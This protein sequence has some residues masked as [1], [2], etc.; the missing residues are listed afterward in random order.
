MPPNAVFLHAATIGTL[1]AFKLRRR[2]RCNLAPKISRLHGLSSCQ[3]MLTNIN[4]MKQKSFRSCG[5]LRRSADRVSTPYIC[6]TC[7]GATGAALWTFTGLLHAW[8]LRLRR[9][10]STGAQASQTLPH[11]RAAVPR[12]PGVHTV[13]RRQTGHVA[14]GGRNISAL[15]QAYSL[16]L[17][18]KNSAI[19]VI[20][21][22][23]TPTALSK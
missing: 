1:N 15:G 18:P 8:H 23:L 4:L 10:P 2:M 6:I 5:R 7:G 12:D 17:S 3:K 9:P 13:G 22:S 14:P 20:G 11:G 19:G 16:G 21:I